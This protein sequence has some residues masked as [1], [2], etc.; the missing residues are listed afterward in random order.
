MQ[1]AIAERKRKG[2]GIRWIPI[3]GEQLRRKRLPT[4]SFHGFNTMTDYDQVRFIFHS[5]RSDVISSDTVNSMRDD[6]PDGIKAFQVIGRKRWILY[7]Y[8]RFNQD[9]GS[10]D[11]SNHRIIDETSGE[12]EYSVKSMRE[13][14]ASLIVFEKQNYGGESCQF[15]ED[16]P[17]D[18]VMF[19]YSMKETASSAI[20]N[21]LYRPYEFFTEP[22]FTGLSAVKARGDY[23]NCDAIGLKS[24]G[25]ARLRGD[26][27]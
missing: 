21:T 23:P 17:F 2:L 11:A 18:R 26:Y 22:F 5:G 6:L 13:V 12:V 24:L 27:W 1:E 10:D 20:V 3:K 16:C 4:D 7:R 15:N 8:R 14:S 9:E 25:S 19:G